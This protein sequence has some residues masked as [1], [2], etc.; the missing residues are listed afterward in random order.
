[1]AAPNPFN[2][3][4]NIIRNQMKPSVNMNR[5]VFMLQALQ[6]FMAGKLNENTH[7]KCP[8]PPSTILAL[9]PILFI[10]AVLIMLPTPIKKYSTASE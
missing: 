9:T 7:E 10:I 4:Q 6:F 8:R 3:A 5:E 1:M 2:M